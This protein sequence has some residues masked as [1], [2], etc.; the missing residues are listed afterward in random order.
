MVGNTVIKGAERIVFKSNHCK[1][2]RVALRECRSFKICVVAI[3]DA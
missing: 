2:P 1:T 3:L